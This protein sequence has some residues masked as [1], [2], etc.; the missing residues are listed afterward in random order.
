MFSPCLC[1]RLFFAKD[2]KLSKRQ[3]T[4]RNINL[5]TG[6]QT[7]V[8]KGKCQHKQ[9]QARHILKEQNCS[10]YFGLNSQQMSQ[11]SGI[12]LKARLFI[13]NNT[14]VRRAQVFKIC[15]PS[16]RT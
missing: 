4:G 6:R 15:L 1:Q 8:K 16:P 12:Y 9:E 10:V 11:G 5:C 13:Y 7:R 2:L 3:V 14:S